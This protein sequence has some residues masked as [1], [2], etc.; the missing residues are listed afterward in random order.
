M[1]LYF[2]ALKFV[3]ASFCVCVGVCVCERERER[4]RGGGRERERERE[5]ERVPV[6][7]FKCLHAPCVCEYVHLHMIVRLR[8]LD[9]IVITSL[10]L[11]IFSFSMPKNWSHLSIFYLG[12]Q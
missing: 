10:V 6:P 2:S 12:Y 4:E 3:F 7:V 11:R 5:G 9:Q 8:Q 1:S